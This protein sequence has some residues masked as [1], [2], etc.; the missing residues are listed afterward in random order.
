[1]VVGPVWPLISMISFTCWTVYVPGGW[2]GV[3]GHLS[4]PKS[5]GGQAKGN[6][7]AMTGETATWLLGHLGLRWV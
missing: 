2:P 6:E 1:M 4:E 3:G 5:D 7:Q